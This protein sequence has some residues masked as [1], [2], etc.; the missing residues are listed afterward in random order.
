MARYKID[1]LKALKEKGYSSY[2][3]INGEGVGCIIGSSGLQKLRKG[4]LLSRPK[5]LQICNLLEI[6]YEDLVEE[7]EGD[8]KN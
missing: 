6:E 3:L 5:L 8:T 1:V 7:D 4:I 2:K